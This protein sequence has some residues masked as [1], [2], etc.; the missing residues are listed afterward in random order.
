[1]ASGVLDVHDIEC[2]WVLLAADE[3]SNTTSVTSTSDEHLHTVVEL[4]E[5]SNLAGSEVDLDRVSDSDAW[6][7]VADG[8]TVVGDNDWDALDCGQ[9]KTTGV[10][11][12]RHST[13]FSSI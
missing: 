3:G 1:M 8:A 7:W 11:G 5:V 10:N 13:P 9:K 2:S 4:D 6:V 12:N